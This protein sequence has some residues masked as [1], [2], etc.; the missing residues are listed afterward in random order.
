MEAPQHG[1]TQNKNASNNS[2]SQERRW[3]LLCYLPFINL[4]TCL[5]TAVRQINSR[6]CRFHVRQGLMIF[7]LFAVAILI[8]LIS[9]MLSLML[10]GIVLALYAFSLYFTYSGKDF[11]I[12]LLATLADKIPEF[13]L[14]E[15][16]TGKVAEGKEEKQ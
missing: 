10:H 14:Y 2:Y 12:P 7:L 15:V 11:K 13:Y 16:L 3:A 4:V 6:Y 9:V 8:S 5:L 1:Q